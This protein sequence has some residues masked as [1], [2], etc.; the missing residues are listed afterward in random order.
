M[1]AAIGGLPDGYDANQLLLA[2]NTATAAAAGAIDA[3]GAVSAALDPDVAVAAVHAVTAKFTAFDRNRVEAWFRQFEAEMTVRGISVDKTKA[4]NL[5]ALL[6]GPSAA[7]VGVVNA[8]PVVGR[9]Y[10]D[11]KARFA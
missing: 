2:V 4:A 1:D 6:V 11:L 5:N 10:E 9:L 7:V 3:V 8:H